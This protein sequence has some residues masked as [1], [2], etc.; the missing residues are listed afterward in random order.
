MLQA[1]QTI[2]I[3]HDGI[4]VCRNEGGQ[5]IELPESHNNHPKTIEFFFD[6]NRVYLLQNGIIKENKLTLIL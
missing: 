2:S 1:P 4:E 5:W 3:R 6:E